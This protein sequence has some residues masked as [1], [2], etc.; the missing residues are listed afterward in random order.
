MRMY[1]LIWLLAERYLFASTHE[2]TISTMVR[3]CFIG[4]LVGTCSLALVVSVMKGF[5]RAT[6]DQ[7]QG[8]HAQIIMRAPDGQV[9]DSATVET[10]LAEKFSHSV[11]AHSPSSMAQVII[12]KPGSD[13]INNVITL[14]G[15]HPEKEAQTSSI[16]QK[17]ITWQTEKK[18]STILHDNYILIGSQCAQSLGVHVGDPISL[19]YVHQQKSARRHRLEFE[20]V[21][22]IVSGIFKTGIEEFDNSLALCSL[23]FFEKLFPDIGITHINLRLQPNS[24]EQGIIHQLENYFDLDVYGWQEMY[25]ALVQALALEKYAMFLILMLMVLVACMSIASLIFMLIIQKRGDIAILSAMGMQ[26]RPLNYVFLL[27][28]TLLTATSALLGLCLAWII[29][30]LVDHFH[31]ITLP[32]VYYVSYLPVQLEIATFG[33][34]FLLVTCMGAGAAWLPAR[35]IRNIKIADVLRFEA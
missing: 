25:P 26:A 35:N 12:Q 28:G 29:G 5:E 14:R 30:M 11:V 8:I 21:T 3:I 4:I 18:L 23:N 27:I 34:I 7:L 6:H 31:L 10:A 33:W 16:E 1:R 22:A 15:I 19:L 13:D 9:I 17:I 20:N 32:D 2:R 24:D